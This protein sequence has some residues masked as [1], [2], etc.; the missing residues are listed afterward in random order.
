M[1]YSLLTRPD[2]LAAL[3]HTTLLD[4]PP[5]EG[6]DRLTRM[7]SRLLGTPVALI[8]LV[9]EDRQFFK[10]AIGL[11]EPWA[12]RRAAPISFSFCSQVVSTGEQLILEDARRHPLLRHST[13][14][15]ELGWVSYAGVP[16]V[17]RDGQTIGSFSVVD[18]MP[19]LWSERDIALLKDL[20]ACAVTEIELRR[21]IGRR[22][23]AEL[24]RRESDEQLQSTFEH[25]GVGLATISLDGR[26]LRVNRALSDLLHV[27]AD[28]LIGYPVEARTHPD[29]VPADREAMRLLLA[30]EAQ[31]YHIEKRFVTGSGDILWALVNVSLVPAQEGEPSHLIVGIQ[32]ITDRKEAESTLRSSEERYRLVAQASQEMIWDWDLSSNAVSWDPGTGPLLDYQRPELGDTADWWYDRL[33]PEDRERVVESLN[34]AIAQGESVWS[35]EYRFRRADGGYAVVQDRAYILHDETGA[36]TRVVSAMA[37]LT[38]G[39]RSE[40]RLSQVLDALPLGIWIVDR[41]GRIVLENAASQRIWGSL[42]NQGLDQLASLRAK[43]LSSG[44]RLGSADWAVARTLASGIVSGPEEVS[45]DLP[46]GSQRVLA[47]SAAPVRNAEGATVGAVG[48][49]EDITERRAH[50]AAAA[51]QQ[52]QERRTDKMNSIGRLAGG[53]AHDFNNLLTGILSYAELILQELRPNDPLRSDVEQIQHAGQRAAGLTRQLLAFSRR[54]VLQPKVVSLRTLLSELEPMLGRLLGGGVALD[55]LLDP[56]TS[57]VMVDP[58]QL[59]QV[60][61]NLILNARDALPRGGRVT[62]STRNA[63]DVLDGEGGESEYVILSVIDTGTGMD[64]ETQAHIFEPFF[65]TKHGAGGAGL[66]LPTVYG[67]VEQSGGH[68]RVESAVGQGTEFLIYLPRYTGSEPAMVP[69]EPRETRGGSETLLLVEDEATVRASVRRLLEWHGYRVL[70][71]GNG[72][73]A[74][75]IYEENPS[76]IDL[77]LT[78]LAMPEMGGAELVERLRVRNPNL[79]VVFMSGY[80][81]RSVANNGAMPPGTAFIEKPF[82]VDTLMRRLREVLDAS[83]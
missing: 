41:H 38:E 69:P 4:T 34:G 12:S 5:E 62:I 66:G 42:R 14:I 28:D 27:S 29:D 43:W 73:E 24:G 13:A 7:A 11:P 36:P 63:A 75:R 33:H 9:A 26:W 21:E 57:N 15:R 8:S 55:L 77:V 80:A 25:A 64:P 60:L 52:D 65:T 67:I 48:V 46:D 2:R 83:V 35:E 56:G 72:T 47:T 49:S 10:S 76:A 51:R 32:D 18:K 39:R 78:D 37:D 1:T 22:R 82:T 17:T 40:R 59:E 68:V 71:A 58:S 70:E 50:E 6:F 19:R 81:E 74:L 79:R 53:V 23:H 20:A 3:R 30:G 54:Q 44:K 45:L 31:N 61:V 16:L